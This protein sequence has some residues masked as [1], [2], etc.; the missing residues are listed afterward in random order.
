MFTVKTRFGDGRETL[1]EVGEIQLDPDPPTGCPGQTLPRLTGT[2]LDGTAVALLPEDRIK[3]ATVY[4]MNSNGKTVAV[5]RLS[6]R[7][8]VRTPMKSDSAMKSDSG[9]QARQT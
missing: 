6:D 1:V 4:V 2:L 3:A 7:G 9:R 8:E 5:Y